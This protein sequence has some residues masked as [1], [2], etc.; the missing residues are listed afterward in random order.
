MVKFFSVEHERL[1]GTKIDKNQAEVLL[2]LM[3]NDSEAKTGCIVINTV[4]FFVYFLEYVLQLG[5][6]TFEV[7]EE[8]LISLVNEEIEGDTIDWDAIN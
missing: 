6:T 5:E 8:L 3:L 7:A 4:R 1:Y 2:K